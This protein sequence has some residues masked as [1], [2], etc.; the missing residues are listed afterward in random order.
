M[1]SLYALSVGFKLVM[2]AAKHPVRVC[3]VVLFSGDG[4]KSSCSYFSFVLCRFEYSCF[5]CPIA[6]LRDSGIL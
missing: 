6:V 3:G 1:R 4:V 2:L 5:K